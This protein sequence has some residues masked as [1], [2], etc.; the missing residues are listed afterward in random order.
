[1]FRT[2]EEFDISEKLK[3][4]GSATRAF[5]VACDAV[6]TRNPTGAISAFLDRLRELNDAHA[7][8]YSIT[9]AGHSMGAIVT[10]EILRRYP[11]LPYSN[12]VY[13][14]AACTI[15]DFESA[16]VPRLQDHPQAHF[17]NLCLS[18]YNEVRETSWEFLNLAPRGSLLVWIDGFFS[19]PLIFEDRMLGRWDNILQ[20]TQVVPSQL[21]PQIT[22]KAFGTGPR[23]DY[24]PQAHGDFGGTAF[25][26]SDMW[27]ASNAW[28]NTWWPGGK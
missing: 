18:P 21:G 3:G 1:M 19:N 15:G 6:G 23:F 5:A 22:I 8:R 11:D 4:A 25:W 26:D 2:P 16:V 27:Q 7:N 13:M 28:K 17:Y 24:G 14:A 10:S 12:I 20:A 9:I